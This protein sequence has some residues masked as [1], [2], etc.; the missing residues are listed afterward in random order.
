MYMLVYQVGCVFLPSL[1]LLLTSS[2]HQF[3]RRQVAMLKQGVA[4]LEGMLPVIEKK[5][6]ESNLVF[7]R[8]Q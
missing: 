4:S 5:M 3:V 8:L 2:F 6:S 7:H 1:F